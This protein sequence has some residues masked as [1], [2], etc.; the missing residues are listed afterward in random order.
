[1][2][3]DGD[4]YSARKFEYYYSVDNNAAAHQLRRPGS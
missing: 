3:I 1:M 2:D 4:G